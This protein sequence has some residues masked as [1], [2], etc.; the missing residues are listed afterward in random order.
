MP[1]SIW[2]FR[3]QLTRAGAVERLSARFD[4][5]LRKAGYLAMGGQIVNAT[6]IE[7]RRP[8]LTR[9]EKATIK[10]WRRPSGWPKGKRAQ[11]ETEGRWMLR[12]GRRQSPAPGKLHERTR[13]EF[14]IPVFGYKDHLG[15]DRRHDFIRSFAVTDAAAHDG[16][17]LGKLLDPRNPA[18]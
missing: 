14:V 3:E 2:L 4:R 16:R 12:R 10:G 9:S 17:Q 13:S 18:S 15:I 5:V 11:T 6:I 1:K 8:R 7:A